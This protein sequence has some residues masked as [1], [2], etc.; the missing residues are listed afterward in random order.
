[1]KQRVGSDAPI[2]LPLSKCWDYGRVPVHF[3][4]GG[5]PRVSRMLGRSFH[6]L[7]YVSQMNS[8]SYFWPSFW[9]LWCLQEWI[10]FLAGTGRLSVLT[11]KY[12]L[13]R[14][15][16]PNRFTAIH[17]DSQQCAFAPPLPSRFTLLSLSVQWQQCRVRVVSISLNRFSWVGRYASRLSVQAGSPGTPNLTESWLSTIGSKFSKNEESPRNLQSVMLLALFW[18]RVLMYI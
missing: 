16:V 5:G 13:V 4:A 2:C 18:N 17:S 1:M 15:S 11:T 12:L 10:Q 7:S 3:G 14:N 6:Q 8:D 9:L